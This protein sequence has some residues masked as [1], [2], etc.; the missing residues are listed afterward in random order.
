METSS[1]AFLHQFFQPG[2]SRSC[3]GCHESREV[4]SVLPSSR[5]TL[6]LAEDAPGKNCCR[7]GV[8]KPINFLRD[9]QPV[10]EPALPFQCHFRP[11]PPMAVLTFCGG[12]IGWD[13]EIQHYG[14]NRAYEKPSWNINWCPC[15]R[16]GRK[17]PA[18]L[19]PMAY[20]SHNSKLITALKDTN[21]QRC[22]NIIRRR[23]VAAGDVD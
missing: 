18:S 4:A 6:A 5:T 2:E 22:G 10:L 9:V 12:L 1:Y 21:Q 7:P 15:R 8:T 19:P 16:H 3:V 20:G 13:K 11:Y 14:H 23:P 17:M